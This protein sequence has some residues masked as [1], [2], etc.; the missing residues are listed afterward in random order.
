M[1][2]SAVRTAIAAAL[3]A[4]SPDSRASRRD[5]FV[6]VQTGQREQES[7]VDRSF[8]LLLSSQP[9]RADSDAI[10]TF[11]VEYQLS[12]FYSATL[13]LANEGGGAEDRIGEDSERV[14]AAL[15]RLHTQSSD[16]N[17]CFPEPIGV[18]DQGGQ[19]K[20]QWSV[21]VNYRLTS[22]VEA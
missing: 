6:Y 20:S 12:I 5:R 1:R 8:V 15:D 13:G 7:L 11:V 4:I 9:K 3:S 10:S 22:G 18:V 16:I 17:A 14:Y 21:V 2:T 19:L